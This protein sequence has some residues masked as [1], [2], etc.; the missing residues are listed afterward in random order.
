MINICDYIYD[1]TKEESSACREILKR[2]KT[3]ALSDE[4][5][6]P[7][8]TLELIRLSALVQP[9]QKTNVRHSAQTISLPETQFRDASLRPFRDRPA[10]IRQELRAPRVRK[11]QHI[12]GS[13]QRPSAAIF[14]FADAG[15]IEP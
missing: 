4:R 10:S 13:A 14:F 15:I 6:R 8:R 11:A 12:Q 2:L 1:K 3:N 9:F 7:I 5:L